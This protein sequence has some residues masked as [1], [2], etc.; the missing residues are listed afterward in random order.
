MEDKEELVEATFYFNNGL[1][2]GIIL[3]MDQAKELNK[4][5]GDSVYRHSGLYPRFINLR[6]VDYISFTS[7]FKP[8]S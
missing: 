8:E 2:L 4:K 1:K 3:T 5:E 6:N 7:N